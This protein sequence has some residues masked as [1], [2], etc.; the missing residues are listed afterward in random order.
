MNLKEWN[1]ILWE[2]V[3]NTTTEISVKL[4]IPPQVLPHSPLAVIYFAL[5]PPLLLDANYRFIGE[6]KIPHL[7]PLI[8]LIRQQNETLKRETLWEMNTRP[9][10]DGEQE[11]KKRRWK[12]KDI[13]TRKE[14]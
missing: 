4:F 5:L 12:E 2:C 13:R 3:I 8:H 9:S 10:E 11:K 6:Q 7:A 14:K 1:C